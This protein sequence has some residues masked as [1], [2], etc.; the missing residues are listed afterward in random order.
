MLRNLIGGVKATFRKDERSHELNEELRS[1]VEDSTSEKMRRG[2]TYDEAQRAARVEMGSMETVKHKVA[3]AGWESTAEGVWQDIRYSARML[4]KS[5][6]FTIVAIL[7]LA[8]GIGAN[9]AIFTLINTLMLQTLP[10]HE[11]QQL[12]AFGAEI[13]GGTVDG[14]GPGPLDIFPYDF[15]QRLE[16]SQDMFQDITAYASFPTT[17]SVRTDSR[18][19]GQARQ[20]ISHLVSGNF[21]SVLGAAPFLGRPIT[22]QDEDAPGRHPVAVVSYA[23]WQQTLA[24]DP[25]VIGRTIAINGMPFTVIGVMP[26]KFYGV[27]LNEESPDMWLPLTMQKEAMLQ[28]SLL[29]PHGLFWLHFMGR[30]KPGMNL[31]QAQAWVTSQLQRFMVNRE[32]AQITA[33]RRQEIQK[34]YVELQPGEHGISHLR[35]QYSK[36][37]AILMVVVI[38]VL[39]I[40][41]ANLANFLLSKAA[42]REREISTRLALGSSRGRI[43]RQVLIE[44]MLLSISGGVLGLLFAFWGTRGLIHFVTAGSHHTALAASPDIR[45]LAFTFGVSLLT[46]LLFGI[47]PALRVSRVRVAPTLSANTRNAI[48]SGGDSGRLLPKLLVIAQV[49]LSIILLACA[50]LFLRTLK[51]LQ[52]QDFGFNRSNLL[53]IRFNPKFAGYKPEQLNN[54]YERILDRLNALPGVRSATIAGAP[55]M[56]GGSW[57]SPIRVEGYTPQPNEDIGTLLNRVGPR[58]FETLGTPILRGRPIGPE[59]TSTSMK[60]VVVNQ[61]LA[62]H[63]FPKGDAIGHRFTVDDPSVK[64]SW[65]IVGIVRDSKYN[66]PREEPQRMAYLALMQLTDDDN[67]A[68][69]L[70]VRTTGEPATVTSEV[71]QALPAIDPNLPILNV[72]TMSEQVDLRMGQETLVSQL[73]SFF[74]L[75]AVSLACIGLYGV[76]TYNVLCRTNEI[77]IRLALGAQ[78]GRVLWMVL[79]ES[80]LLLLIGVALGVPVTLAVS[81]AIQSQLFG[82]SS[83]DPFTLMGTVF[84]IAIVTLLAA[85]FPA[86]RA[87]KVDPMVALRYE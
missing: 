66:N 74:S 32:G 79:R 48:S 34:I 77:G 85:Y 65:Q 64:G 36:P 57:N 80:L 69:V 27:D 33:S 43:V 6:G 25:S 22:P 23:Y 18:A 51:N 28:P 4:A 71:R 61:T 53:L 47:A 54:L 26:A 81:R 62:D 45:V 8:L 10:V 56:S 75:L 46:G 49:A 9:T 3:A 41:C 1:F 86:W 38:L 73:S 39:C 55:P 15:Y 68:Y 58:Y 50:G 5:P 42:S 59:D 35:E 24:A 60:A 52:N 21:F 37:L 17:V 67:Y 7:S 2:M 63:F 72:R 14:I 13:G 40:A 19:T 70:Q 11:P 44:A 84:G 78:T 29:D 20:A 82:L 31:S 87:S 83:A 30:R 76:M 16:K 12:V